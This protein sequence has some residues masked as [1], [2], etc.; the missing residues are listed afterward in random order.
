MV[1]LKKARNVFLIVAIGLTFAILFKPIEPYLL[2]FADGACLFLALL[3][4]VVIY[5]KN[6][7]EMDLD[8]ETIEE[9]QIEETP[10][11]EN[12]IP[13]STI[14]ETAT[15]ETENV[16]E[17]V[18]TEDNVEED[19]YEVLEPVV[20]ADIPE[21]EIARETKV[22]DFEVDSDEGVVRIFKK[23]NKMDDLIEQ[24]KEHSFEYEVRK[25]GASNIGTFIKYFNLLNGD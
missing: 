23:E 2:W 24:L 21:E 19:N 10:K 18:E 15:E 16:T 11:L 22:T 25:I 1:G 3:L 20:P 6:T 8:D 17:S 9:E 14:E 7:S 5:D 12:D 13:M 4:S